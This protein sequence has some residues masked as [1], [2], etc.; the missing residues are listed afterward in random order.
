MNDGVKAI[1]M[2]T[3]NERQ[4]KIQKSEPYQGRPKMTQTVGPLN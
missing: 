4:I 3:K 2:I 1:E